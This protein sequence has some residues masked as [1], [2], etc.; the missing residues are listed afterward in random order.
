MR[1]FFGF[2]VMLLGSSGYESVMAQSAGSFKAT[3]NLTTPRVGH[4]ATLL[5]NGKVLIAG[6]STFS[7]FSVSL[8]SAE[9]YDPSNGTF[10]ST[11]NMTTAR[12]LHTAALLPNGK[13][14]IAGGTS[15]GDS[16][17]T[18]AELYDPSTGTFAATGDMIQ[19]RHRQTA[20]LVNNGKVL[21]AGGA[22]TNYGSSALASAEL[23]D[24]SAGAFTAA[25][26]MTTARFD[27]TATL[28]SNGKVLIDGSHIEGPVSDH[29]EVYDPDTNTFNATGGTLDAQPETATL[30]MNVKVLLTRSVEASPSAELYDPSTGTFS[31]SGQM[32]DSFRN[33]YTATMLP[34]GAILIA[35]GNPMGQALLYDPLAGKFSPA[36]D[37]A[38]FRR[39][40][41]ATLLPD[42]AVLIAGGYDTPPVGLN[43]AQIYK[44]AVPVPTPVLFALSQ[45]GPGQGAIWHAATGQVASPANPANAGEV[46][47]M[48]TTSLVDGGVIPPQVSIGG[49]LAEV[50]F[51]GNAPGYPGFNQ[52]NFRVPGG[53]A[54]GPAVPV[55]L[56]YLG[57][58]SKTVTIGAQ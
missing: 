57:R 37:M 22:L 50:F 33:Q 27:H 26:D 38:I 58:P 10:T 30:L 28:L 1:R 19:A 42:G 6:G 25:G 40:H 43:S 51:F 52:V 34:D 18:S 5:T 31:P 54:S 47:A 56:T 55:R 17:L 39:W 2:L 7:H 11:G 20:T 53:V 14:L 45:D 3:G 35:G 16:A 49:R 9:L 32:G 8:A 13:V 41:T 15:G 24:S 12:W 29:A 44:P 48:Y 36:G 21:I 23:Y 46:L 4:S